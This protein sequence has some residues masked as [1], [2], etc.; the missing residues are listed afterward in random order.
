MAI[1]SPT[2]L[3]GLLESE[4][5]LGPWSPSGLGLSPARWVPKNFPGLPSINPLSLPLHVSPDSAVEGDLFF[6]AAIDQAEKLDPDKAPT[7]FLND[8]GVAEGFIVTMT[9]GNQGPHC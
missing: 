9:A 7:I 2:L 4:R 5:S 8:Q 1:L 3:W 6:E